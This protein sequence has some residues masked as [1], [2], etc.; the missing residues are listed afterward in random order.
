LASRVYALVLG[1]SKPTVAQY[2]ATLLDGRRAG[3]DGERGLQAHLPQ[4][5]I[6]AIVHVTAPDVPKSGDA[7]TTE[8][9]AAGA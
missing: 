9:A 4:Y 1:V 6:D 2:L 3:R 8:K 7:P 5:L